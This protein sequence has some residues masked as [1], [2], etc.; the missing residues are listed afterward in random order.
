MPNPELTEYIKAALEKGVPKETIV[1]TL[2][3][4]GWQEQPIEE[5]FAAFQTPPQTVQTEIASTTTS[6]SDLEPSVD[7]Q[8]KNAWRNF[9]SKA[10]PFIIIS[11]VPPIFGTLLQYLISPL[12]AL[13]S[14]NTQANPMAAFTLLQKLSSPGVIWTVILSLIVGFLINLIIQSISQIALIYTAGETDPSLGAAY[15][16][17][18]FKLFSYWWIYILA[19]FFITGGFLLFIV[20][21]I[22]FGIWFTF[23]FYVLILENIK[24]F[25]ALLR[26]RAL[27][28]NFWFSVY[29][30][31]LV[32]ITLSA[33]LSIP[34]LIL[35]IISLVIT[36]AG[37]FGT[38]FSSVAGPVIAFL[39]S[40]ASSIVG[41]FLICYILEVFKGLQTA[42]S[43]SIDQSTSK[44]LILKLGFGGYA[45]AII[46]LV[47]VIFIVG[48][49]PKPK[50]TLPPLQNNSYN[51]QYNLSPTPNPYAFPT[52]PVTISPT[53]KVQFPSAIPG[54]PSSG[55]DN[56]PKYLD[57]PN[58]T[59]A[60]RRDFTKW[61]AVV[62]LESQLAA[63]RITANGYPPT[64][65]T[66]ITK[67]QPGDQQTLKSSNL[68]YT[69]SP[70][71]TQYTLCLT[72]ET[73]GNRCHI[74]Q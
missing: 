11:L 72:F 50:S 69:A 22:I 46:M 37:I 60:G 26:S 53:P 54:S 56:F 29:A 68:L 25:K 43:N 21:G 73:L 36:Y 32:S 62:N 55:V 61:L 15:K 7:S 20:P 12:S 58:T 2:L 3:D 65:D 35:P 49:L 52:T 63:L 5:A 13:S 57:F 23:V 66:V 48:S 24:G 19:G 9:S 1:A 31:I 30:R 51:N 71:K 70:D 39:I 27:V 41:A 42:K 59:D 40:T 67:L 33:I 8:I 45:F 4:Q 18:L 64:L 14:S 74:A 38:S 47:A 34:L 6:R 10:T 17:G 44:G 16:K 28:K